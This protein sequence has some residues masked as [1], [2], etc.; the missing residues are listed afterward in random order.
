MISLIV[1]M[2]GTG[3][4]K[5]GAYFQ[6]NLIVCEPQAVHVGLQLLFSFFY[7]KKNRTVICPYASEMDGD[8]L[9]LDISSVSVREAVHRI[10]N[11]TIQISKDSGARVSFDL[12]G[13]YESPYSSPPVQDETTTTSTSTSTTT[14]TA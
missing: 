1:Q 11:K 7:T 10:A 13:E 3:E 9:T 8:L 6:S 2:T 14:S 12:E 5:R 4:E